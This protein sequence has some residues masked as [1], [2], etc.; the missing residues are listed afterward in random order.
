M[1]LAII[2]DVHANLPALEA[3]L[4]EIKAESA[5]RILCLGDIVGYGASPNECCD[6]L[7]EAKVVSVKGNHDRAAVEPGREE[8]F[9]PQAR[10]CLLWT[11]E[12]LSERNKRWLAPFPD[13]RQVERVTLCHGSLVEP[14]DYV[15]SWHE[16]MPS[17]VRLGTRIAFLGHTHYAAWYYYEADPPRGD[18]EMVPQPRTIKVNLNGQYLV[19]PGAVGQPRDGNP[20]AAYLLYDDQVE[21]IRFRRVEYDIDQAATA[22]VEAGLPTSMAARLYAGM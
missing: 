21:E 14:D 3:V 22:I 7:R 16:A 19:N 5:H 10:A 15:F 13:V 20:A 9:T 8:W 1:K 18:G 11:R 12:V 6:R 2:S 17:F 4:A